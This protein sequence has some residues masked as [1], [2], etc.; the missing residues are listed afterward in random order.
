M[1]GIGKGGEGLQGFVFAGFHLGDNRIL[2]P[3]QRSGVANPEPLA[4]RAHC[5]S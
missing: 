5:F 4:F 1:K 2:V 3:K